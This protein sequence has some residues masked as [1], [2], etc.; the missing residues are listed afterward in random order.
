MYLYN[1][2]TFKM[3][4]ILG[5]HYRE[6]TCLDLASCPQHRLVTGSYD[7]RVRVFDLR[8]EKVTHSF[9]L[10]HKRSVTAVQMDDWKVVSGAEDGTLMV[11]DQRMTSPLWMT[12]A[13]HPVKLCKF[14]GPRMFTANI[15]L[16]KTARE[17]L[18]YADDLI[19]HRRHRGIIRLYDFS[20]KN[21]TEG[22]PEICSSSY[23]DTTGYNY[24]IKLSVPYDRIDDA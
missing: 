23:D 20:A 16:D 12:R 13:R 7:C 2:E 8:S 1:L 6:I 15:P 9:H 4:S 3:L 22:I 11:W 19:L 18:W 24:N 14:E 17:N 10:G 21:S 5:G